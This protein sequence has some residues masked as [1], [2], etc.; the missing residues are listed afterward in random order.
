ME[1]KTTRGKRGASAAQNE[2]TVFN[3]LRKERVIIKHVPK[4]SALIHNPKHI[5]YGGMSEEASRWFTVPM[6]KSGQL[7]DVLTKEEKTFLEEAMGLENNALS[8]YRKKDNYWSNFMVRL[9]KQDN[10]LDLSVPEDY[11]KYKVLLANKDYIAPSLDALQT[12]PKATY[13]FVILHEQEEAKANKKRVNSTVEAYKEFGKIEDDTNKL[14]VILE[15]A[16][17]K[18]LS[19]KTSAEVLSD[20]IDKLIKADA[21]LFLRVAQDP[22]LDTKVLLKRGIEVGAVILR[23]GLLYDTDGKPLCDKGDATLSVAAA[24]INKP[25]HQALKMAIEAKI[26]DS[27]K[28]DE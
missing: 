14:R 11:I 24:Y 26:T 16:T 8:I 18:P 19:V 2:E 1:E 13:E 3:P 21:R 10:Y 22:M 7:Y 4:E 17:G 27:E 28:Q 20:R 12:K 5:N 6:L 23:N 9:Q 25:A 15:T